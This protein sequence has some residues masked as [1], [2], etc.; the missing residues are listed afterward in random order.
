MI[1]IVVRAYNDQALIGDTLRGI[2]NQAAPARILVMDNEST[3]GTTA[4]CK[5]L[6]DEVLNVPAGTY[7]PGKVLNRAM[8][9]T[10][11][12]FVVFLNSDCTP[13]DDNWLNPLIAGFN[14][15]HVAAVFSRQRPRPDC[16]PLFAKDTEDTF[17][18]GGR[19]EKWKHCFS[20]ASSAVRRSA[21]EILPFSENIQ[22]SED[23]DWTWRIRQRGFQINY[24]P[25]SCVYHS[26]N[27]TLKQWRRRQYG[28]GKADAQIF[29]WEDW[30]KSWLRYSAMPF[31]RQVLSDWAHAAKVK[32]PSAFV[33]S[34]FLRFAQMTGRRRGFCDGLDN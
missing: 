10:K 9:A 13:A 34:P 19:Q 8:T 3:D 25:D 33:H 18:D 24:C 23:I 16:L 15:E 20:M 29:E 30:E 17:G 2:R 28:E 7:V 14:A 12:E 4:I 22:Y 5:E 1:D 26:H 21:W 27:Y 31:V 32:S 6:A 11:S